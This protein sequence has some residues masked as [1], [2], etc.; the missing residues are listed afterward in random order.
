MNQPA[1]FWEITRD[2][3]LDC[4]HCLT[5][6]DH[7]VSEELSTY[8][9]YKTVDQIVAIKPLEVTITGGDPLA[10]GDLFQIIDYATRRGLKPAV[11]VTATANLTTAAIENLRTA[12][13]ARL[14]F[15]LNGATAQRHD[16]VSG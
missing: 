3:S 4:R 8:E 10:R 11:A 7:R 1:V 2:C 5:H 13:A 15:S 16:Q 14:I 6:E 9:A 12:G